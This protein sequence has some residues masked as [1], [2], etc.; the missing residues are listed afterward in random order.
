MEPEIIL[1]LLK[2]FA[3]SEFTPKGD[4]SKALMYEVGLTGSENSSSLR[5][6]LAARLGFPPKMTPNA[7]L[8]A[9]NVLYT[10]E[11]FMEICKD[12]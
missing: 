8:A 3:D 5:E 1:N 10:A 9:L 11:E 4:I 6:K 12:I 2:P 7:L